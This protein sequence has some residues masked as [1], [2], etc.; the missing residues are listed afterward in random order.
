[1]AA[2]VDS[3]LRNRPARGDADSVGFFQMRLS[4]WDAGEYKGFPSR[5]QLQLRWFL[6]SAIAMKMQRY[7]R[8]AN[9][10]DP[11]SWGDWVADVERP[12]EAFRG[13][14]QLRLEEARRLLRA[15]MP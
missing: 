8:G 10:A 13:R 5:P 1:M 4:I 12:A 7:A 3:G 2:L 11:S 14:Y 6:D 15:T 9:P